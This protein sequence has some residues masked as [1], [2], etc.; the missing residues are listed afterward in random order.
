MVSSIVVHTLDGCVKHIVG[1]RIKSKR[2]FQLFKQLS[3]KIADNLSGI[4]SYKCYI[5]GRFVV[6]DHDG[7]TATISR[8]LEGF[9]RRGKAHK[10][11]VVVTDAVG[12]ANE[13]SYDFTW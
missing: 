9:P 8:S 12:N 5:D 11:K 6:F 7:K 3:L 10:L 13:T 4:A 2:G 1:I